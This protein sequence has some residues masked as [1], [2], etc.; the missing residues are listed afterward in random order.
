MFEDDDEEESQWHPGWRF[1]HLKRHMAFVPKGFIRY[2]VLRLLNE[3]PMSGSEIIQHI[4]ENSG[5]R[6]RP[7]PGS[8][9]P[10][11]AWL[12]EKKYI[13]EVPSEEAGIKRYTLTDEGKKFLEEHEKRR[14]E[15]GERFKAFGPG[16]FF[17]PPW[18]A[19]P[20]RVKTVIKADFELHNA[21][22]RLRHTAAE[23]DAE[24]IT[25]KVAEILKDSTAKI[26]ELIK[27]YN[28]TH[29]A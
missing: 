22:W 21:L 20:E 13:K 9:Y 23:K 24:E 5:G 29:K 11:L 8:I 17:E 1:R 26:E 6:W 27:K 3:K 7:S 14:I 16:F 28:T 4:E 25:S 12:Q 18:H 19:M 15:M 10:L 2:Y